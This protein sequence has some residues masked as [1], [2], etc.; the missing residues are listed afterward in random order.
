MHSK[1][2]K[3]KKMKPGEYRENT[4]STNKK[5]KKKKKRKEWKNLVFNSNY[6]NCEW[7]IEQQNHLYMNLD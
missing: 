7:C 6:Y 4:K 5:K 3:P 1:E 2:A